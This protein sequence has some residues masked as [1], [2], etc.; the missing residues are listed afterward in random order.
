MFKAKKIER[1]QVYTVFAR[2][3]IGAAG[4]YCQA[5]H[6]GTQSAGSSDVFPSVAHGWRGL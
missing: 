4:S 1:W 6:T 2:G 3:G 5:L